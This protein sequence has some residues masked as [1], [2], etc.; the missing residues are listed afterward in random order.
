MM[1]WRLNIDRLLNR[2]VAATVGRYTQRDA[3]GLAVADAAS[4]HGYASIR[5]GAIVVGAVNRATGRIDR[6]CAGLDTELR[7]TAALPSIQ[8]NLAGIIQATAPVLR[9]CSTKRNSGSVILTRSG[10]KSNSL[11]RG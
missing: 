8:R 10:I 11:G 7:D 2:N 4:Q 9:S 1:I 3:D 5:D 6:N